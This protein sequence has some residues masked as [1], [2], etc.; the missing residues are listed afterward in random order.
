MALLTVPGRTTGLPRSVPVALAPVEDGWT[1]I[2]VYGVSD[3]SKNLD[4]AG[5]ATITVRGRTTEVTV[6]RL[7]PSL[8]APILRDAISNAP[9]M[10][11]RLTA[12]YYQ[13]KPDSPPAAW[14]DEAQ[15]HPVY[16][17]A[18]TPTLQDFRRSQS[19]ASPA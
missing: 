6:E 11:R 12:K 1:L 3:W 14:E 19:D 5:K 7:K 10:V 13:A 8:A 17:L 2:S 18:P 4:A 16:L 15:T 9:R